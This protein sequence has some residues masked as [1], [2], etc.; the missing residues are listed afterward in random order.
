MNYPVTNYQEGYENIG[1][2][3]GAAIEAVPTAMH[4]QEQMKREREAYE[5]VKEKMNN[6]KAFKLELVKAAEETVDK[7]PYNPQEKERLKSVVM[8]RIA[9]NEDVE[10]SAKQVAQFALQCE[11]YRKAKASSPGVTL[12]GPSYDWT[13]EQY[14]KLVDGM[15][16][17]FQNKEAQTMAAE[18]VGTGASYT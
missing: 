1:N 13:E 10:E 15:V 16:N 12:V 18:P 3:L 6:K 11:I 14:Q 17:Q 7:S 8:K 9:A 2:K 5:L 4:Q